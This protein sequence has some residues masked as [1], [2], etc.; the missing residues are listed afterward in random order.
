MSKSYKNHI[1]LSESD[2]SIR[3]KLKVMQTDPARIRRDDPGN[4]DVCPV[5][6]LHKVFSSEE[7]QAK[8][9]EGCRSASIG[10]IECKSWVAD[11]IVAT[12]APIRERRADLER[13]PSV[14]TDVLANGKDR[15]A[16]EPTPPSTKSSTPSAS[17][18]HRRHR[19]H[20][21]PDDLSND[22][23]PGH[24]SVILSE[25]SPSSGE[26]KSKDPEAAGLTG[27]SD[28]LS[29]TDPT[30]PETQHPA[31]EA[32]NTPTQKPEPFALEHPPTPAPPPEPKKKPA[33]TDEASQSPFSI[34]IGQVYEG[35]FDLL[36]DLIRKQN[37]DIYDIPI[38]RITAQF[39]EYTHHLKQTDVDAAGEF[40]YVASLLIHIKSKTLLPRD[41]SDVTGTDSEDPR[42]E[43]VERL[44]EHERFKAAA[45]MLQQKQMLEDATW[46]QPGLKSFLKDEGVTADD[47]RDIA[48]TTNDLLLVFRDILHR[49]RERPVHSID[50]DSVTV[51]QMIDFVKRRLL[52]EDRPISLRRMLH[53]T[54]SERA[55]ICTFLAMLELVRL[56]AIVLRQPSLEGDILI[57]KTENFEQIFADQ[58]AIRDDWG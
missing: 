10:C 18:N 4:P 1:E 30:H 19:I 54:K 23:K 17:S 14:V 27:T 44:L 38:A 39:L 29:P 8:A 58:A 16:G 5:F 53:N 43:L 28:P 11:A 26:A 7:T 32:D 40:I 22:P 49:L 13:R 6:D 21:A 36:L 42:R 25:A 15:A 33:A 3:A 12:I 57:K 56:Q 34:T 48:A 2:E 20:L 46:S 31:A 37:I 50:E 24:E 55:L 35:P 51:A 41:P 52:L 47:E 45:Q 9:A